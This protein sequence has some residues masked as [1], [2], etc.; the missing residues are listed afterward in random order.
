MGFESAN[1]FLYTGSDMPLSY[2][3]KKLRGK[4]RLKFGTRRCKGVDVS[5][6]YFRIEKMS[7]AKMGSNH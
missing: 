4:S 1:L 2:L 7:W 6:R 5:K 3:D